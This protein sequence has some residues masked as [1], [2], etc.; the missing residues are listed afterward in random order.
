MNWQINTVDGRETHQL[1]INIDRVV[2]GTDGAFWHWA[3]V[4]TDWDILAKQD[5]Y[6]SEK[7]ARVAALSWFHGVGMGLLSREMSQ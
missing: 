3:A 2:V 5:G 4:N 1:H 6:L 7:L